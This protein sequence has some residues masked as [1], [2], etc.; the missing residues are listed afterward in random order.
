MNKIFYTSD[1]HFGH[2]NIIEYENRPF[3][4]INEMEEI[5]IK[6]WNN[7]VNED[8]DVYILGDVAIITSN[9]TLET[10]NNTVSKLNGKK[11][12][13]LGNHDDWLNKKD[14]KPNIWE[15]ITS[16]KTIKESYTYNKVVSKEYEFDDISVN[17]NSD[18]S[19][20]VVNCITKETINN[21]I[22]LMHYPI[23]HWDRQHYGSIH[24]HGHTHSRPINAPI[25]N[26]YNVGMDLWD[27]EPVT[28]QEIID[29]FGYQEV[30]ENRYND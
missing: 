24:L 19:E 15:E 13:I 17:Y 7:K 8:D 18:N 6:K 20:I 26:R 22:H 30:E 3:K 5:I 28:L 9:Y 27:Y 14:F 4:D 2:K 29:K 12:L 21:S 11:H 10:L 23:E 16:Y 1:I 25:P